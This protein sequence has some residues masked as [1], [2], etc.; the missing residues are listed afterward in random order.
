MPKPLAHTFSSMRVC[1]CV[2]YLC[3]LT[4]RISEVRSP[5][6]SGACAVQYHAFLPAGLEFG[7]LWSQWPQKGHSPGVWQK[8]CW[9]ASLP[10]PETSPQRSHNIN[11]TQH[12]C[13]VYEHL[14]FGGGSESAVGTH[15]A[16]LPLKTGEPGLCCFHE[17]Y[18]HGTMG[19]QNERVSL[20]STAHKSNSTA[21]ALAIMPPPLTSL[22][23]LVTKVYTRTTL[24]IYFK[25]EGSHWRKTY[26]RHLTLLCP[27]PCLDQSQKAHQFFCW[28]Q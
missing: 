17:L 8:E 1:G 26:F 18:E 11:T 27:W 9:W 12:L 13:Q 3:A 19:M 14:W 21:M 16:H 23:L 6:G 2:L 25:R 7:L 22:V 4:C 24:N 5:G 10:F 28:L 20:F 15:L